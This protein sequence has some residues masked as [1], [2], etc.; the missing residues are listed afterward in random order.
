M[1]DCAAICRLAAAKLRRRH[2]HV[3]GDKTVTTANASQRQ[4]QEIKQDERLRHIPVVILSTSQAEQDI[5]QSYRLR[6]NAF[7]NWSTIDSV[8][9]AVRTSAGQS[10]RCTSVTLPSTRRHARTSGDALAP[11]RT[12]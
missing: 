9:S 6:A 11:S 7:I 8:S 10:L 4:W 12:A 3:F 5:V 1:R 2:P